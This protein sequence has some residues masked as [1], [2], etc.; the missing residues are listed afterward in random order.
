MGF[1]LFPVK[2]SSLYT[3]HK[4]PRAIVGKKYWTQI[5]NYLFTLLL[6]KCCRVWTS[7]FF[8]IF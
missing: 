5:S 2:V 1:Q 8:K 3:S 7:I 6:V 4:C